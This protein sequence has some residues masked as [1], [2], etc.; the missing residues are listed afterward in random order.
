[1]A[2]DSYENQ[3]LHQDVNKIDMSSDGMR[4][5]APSIANARENSLMG[6]AP[7]RSVKE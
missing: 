1:M 2:F 3:S 6:I 7:V 4:E 5:V